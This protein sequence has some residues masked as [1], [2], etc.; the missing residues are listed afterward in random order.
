MTIAEVGECHI[1]DALKTVEG[2][3]ML[4]DVSI[5]SVSS[6]LQLG[7]NTLALDLIESIGTDLGKAVE[8]A[9]EMAMAVSPTSAYERVSEAALC[10]YRVHLG[11]GKIPSHWGVDRIKIVSERGLALLS[12]AERFS[13]PPHRPTRHTFIL[14][15]G[16]LHH[17]LLGSLP[18]NARKV[19]LQV[20][21]GQTQSQEAK[22]VPELSKIKVAGT[23]DKVGVIPKEPTVQGQAEDIGGVWVDPRGIGGKVERNS[24]P[25]GLGSEVFRRLLLH[26]LGKMSG[27]SG[28]TR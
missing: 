25:S 18:E 21:T 22:F 15:V 4:G 2:V 11:V 17:A 10:A 9:S 20:Q 8:V 26:H 3:S 24:T 6:Y 27:P 1:R 5:G 7:A 13:N 16:V 28:R 12:F 19:V 14:D 23:L